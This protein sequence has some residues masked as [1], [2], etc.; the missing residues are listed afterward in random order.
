MRVGRC[1][2]SVRRGAAS[3][4]TRTRAHGWAGRGAVLGLGWDSGVG[5]AGRPGA[6]RAGW[7]GARGSGAGGERRSGRTRGSGAE[8]KGEAG[9]G[10]RGKRKRKEKENGKGKWKKEKEKKRR[11]E[12]EK[13]ESEVEGFVPRSRRPVGHARRRACVRGRA[14]RAGRGRTGK[15]PGLEIR[16]LEQGKI[17]GKRVRGLGGF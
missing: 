15:G 11:G 7:Q 2:G 1:R 6:E 8:E 14:R 12:R 16:H 13:K 9:E 17:P 10:R 5:R 4:C 3:A